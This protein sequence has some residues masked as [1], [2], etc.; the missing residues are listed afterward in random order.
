MPRLTPT[1]L[2][3]SAAALLAPLAVWAAS[4]LVAGGATEGELREAIG[5]SRA[6]EQ[7][8]SSAAERLAA[9]EQAIAN[10]IAVLE[11]R[12]GAVQAELERSETRLAD[13]RAELRAQRARLERLRARLERSRGLLGRRLRELYVSRKPDLVT[14]VLGSA[15]LSDLME[16]TEFLR[17]IQRADAAIVETVRRDRDETKAAAARL[18][19]AEQ[20]QQDTVI[21]VRR[22]RDA[23]ASMS[24]ALDERR[25]SLAAARAARLAALRD[26]RADRARAQRELDRLVAER[27]RAARETAPP[28]SATPTATAGP[29][30]PA[31]STGPWAIPWA[32]VQCESG[33]QNLPPNWAGASGYYQFIPATWQ[34]LGGSTEHA[35]QA[36][37]AEQ[38]R[39]AAALWNN[40]AGADNWD[41][42][43]LVAGG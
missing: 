29:G 36:S 13:T 19:D 21:A 8:L 26:S 10:D 41:C 1:R 22:Q 38:D 37:K 43:A 28:P 42:A 6:Q 35:Y 25:A 12:L 39:L 27:E 15:S 23:L 33:G 17:R 9:L 16:R 11:R 30:A 3:A 7:R 34:G 40:G 5:S 18:A 2:A 14:I 20:R 31:T 4:P 32:I 24:A